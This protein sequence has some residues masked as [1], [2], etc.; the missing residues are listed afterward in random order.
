MP[1]ERIPRCLANEPLIS[2]LS[3][4]PKKIG[5]FV[6]DAVTAWIKTRETKTF[7]RALPALLAIGTLG[8][9][10]L[11]GRFQPVSETARKYRGAAARAVEGGDYSAAH[12]YY[13]KLFRLGEDTANTRLSAAAA[14]HHLGKSAERDA[15]L[16][17]LTGDDSGYAPAHVWIAKSM[18]DGAIAAGADDDET[19]RQVREHLERALELDEQ[20]AEAHLLLGQISLA[21]HLHAKTVFHLERVVDSHPQA[22]LHLAKAFRQLQKEDQALPMAERA[23]RH[24]RLE[25]QRESPG[26]VQQWV[27]R[28]NLG[29]ALVFLTR[30]EEALEWLLPEESEG[31]AANQKQKSSA[32]NRELIAEAYVGWS[33]TFRP[34]GLDPIV[35]RMNLKLLNEALAYS[36]A[37]SR[38][39]ERLGRMAGYF[40][41]EEALLAVE[42]AEGLLNE[43]S[44]PH[45]VRWIVGASALRVGNLEGAR[46]HLEIAYQLDPRCAGL[47]GRL[48]VQTAYSI[49]EPQAPEKT[50][51]PPT[52]LLLIDEAISLAPEDGL[53]QSLRR[54]ILDELDLTQP[55]E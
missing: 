23:E 32:K 51:S 46:P 15:L 9:S 6:I 35:T 17:R 43:G 20:H 40:Q 24:F 1:S 31:S 27:A 50:E 8:L 44:Y 33:D 49:H 25:V 38:V 26:S 16:T 29:D 48:A 52:A 55:V 10:L 37:D 22:A 18:M 54:T 47:L 45:L 39:V 28:E 5:W 41:D 30:Y 12:L 36:P 11:E 19:G 14:A 34:D 7:W 4:S 13:Q 21:R 2:D 3:T 53:L 42:T